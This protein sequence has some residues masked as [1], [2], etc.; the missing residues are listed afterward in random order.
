MNNIILEI[1]ANAKKVWVLVFF[2][3]ENNAFLI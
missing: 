2:L 1:H 3:K